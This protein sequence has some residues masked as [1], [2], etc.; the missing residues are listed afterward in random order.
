MNRLVIAAFGAVV[1]ASTI[2]FAV[3]AQTARERA[4]IQPIW[5]EYHSC[6]TCSQIAFNL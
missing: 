1:M 3:Q 6:T 2:S 4:Q 5:L